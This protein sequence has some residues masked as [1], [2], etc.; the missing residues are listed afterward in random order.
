MSPRAKWLPSRISTKSSG[1]ITGPKSGASVSIRVHAYGR[2][3]ITGAPDI[4]VPKTGWCPN[5]RF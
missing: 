1:E 5:L 3:G 2:R 4:A